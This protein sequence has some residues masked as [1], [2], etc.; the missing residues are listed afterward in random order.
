[1]TNCHELVNDVTETFTSVK[2]ASGEQLKV[3][4][5]GTMKKHVGENFI[6]L[7]KILVVPDLKRNLISV[8]C[9]CADGYE[10][11]FTERCIIGKDGKIIVEIDQSHNGLFIMNTQK[12]TN[13]V[14]LVHARLGH[15]GS[16]VLRK[17]KI[18]PPKQICESCTYGEHKAKPVSKTG[19]N[20]V[21]TKNILDLIHMDLIGP[22]EVK[23]FGGAKYVLSIVDDHS[24]FSHVYFLKKKSESFAKFCKYSKLVENQKECRIKAIKS[25]SGGEFISKE[26]QQFLDAKG[27]IRHKSAPYNKKQNGIIERFNRTIMVKARSILFHGN[28]DKQWLAEAVAAANFIRNHLICKPINCSPVEIWSELD[29]NDVDRVLRKL[30]VWGCYCLV[31]IPKNL[32]KKLDKQ[33]FVDGNKEK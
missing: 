23:S 17:H 29:K 2:T 26:F 22:L 15:A 3:L 4:G 33:K 30:K 13:N 32:R 1:M 27:I 16:N 12:E 20:R 25:D 8:A 5:E 18:S 10:V 24:R 31:R 11:K 7:K 6:V 9:L 21:I 28:H 19:S 14:Q